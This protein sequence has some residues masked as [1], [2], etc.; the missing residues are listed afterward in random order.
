EVPEAAGFL[1]S[2][3]GV[4]LGVEVDDHVLALELGQRHALPVRVRKSEIGGLLAFFDLAHGSVSC[5]FVAIVRDFTCIGRGRN[6]M[7]FGPAL[8]AFL[9]SCSTAPQESAEAG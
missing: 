1:G 4:V 5:G 9:V 2:A 7:K 6:E 8:L 3:R